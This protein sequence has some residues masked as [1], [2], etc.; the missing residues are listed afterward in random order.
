MDPNTLFLLIIGGASGY[1]ALRRFWPGRATSAPDLERL[2]APVAHRGAAEQSSAPIGMHDWLTYVNYQPDRVPHLAIIGPSGAGKTT[3]ATAVLADRPGRIVVITAKEGDHWGGLPYIGIDEDAT[4]TTAQRALAQLL[5]E[6]KGRL[7][8]VKHKRMT[9]D[10]LTIVIDDFSTLVKEAEVAADVVKLVARLGRSLRVRLV[11][12]SDSALVKAIGLEGEGETRS[13]F[14]FLRIARGHKSVIEIE[15]EQRPIDTSKVRQAAQQA[16]LADRAWRPRRSEQDE[17][18]EILGVCG[19]EGN[20]EGESDTNKQTNSTHNTQTD[21][22]IAS[23]R[24]ALALAL[25]SEGVKREA[26]RR[27]LNKVGMGFDD[28]QYTRWREWLDEHHP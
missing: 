16:Q 2:G 27:A 8:D 28:Q 17:L 3:L 15:G 4:Y 22:P 24:D 20:F 11:M 13:N 14:A 19:V 26:L 7:V 9:A 21:T 5:G 10:Y 6:V 12:L 25:M 23:Q 1:A 18:Q